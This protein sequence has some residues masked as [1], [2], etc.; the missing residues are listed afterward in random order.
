[1]LIKPKKLPRSST[2]KPKNFI[3]FNI[4]LFKLSV[5]FNFNFNSL[6]KNFNYN[7]AFVNSF[8]LLG[9]RN[10]YYLITL[11][12][13]YNFFYRTLR[14]NLSSATKSRLGEDYTRYVSSLDYL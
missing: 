9:F 10:L 1:L 11:K 5:N 12:H 14:L 4:N 3:K 6:Y 13:F 8:F 7:A 2:L